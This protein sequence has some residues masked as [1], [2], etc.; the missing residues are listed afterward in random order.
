[1]KMLGETGLNSTQ[2]GVLLL[3][4]FDGMHVGHRRLLE[5][6][7]SLEIPVGIM[8]IL[9]GKGD[10]LFT[11]K[12]RELFFTSLGI[13]FSFAFSFE[14]IRGLSSQEFLSF[15]EA[16][17]SPSAYIC[18]DDFRFGKGAEG[19]ATLL[20]ELASVPVFVEELYKVNGEK[21]SSGK[22]KELLFKGEIESANEL[23]GRE[24]FLV[25][26]VE[27]GRKI[28]RTMGFP[29]ANIRYPQGKFPL[30]Q[31]V[32]ETRVSVDGKIHAGITNFGSRPTFDNDEVWTETHLKGFEGDLYGKTLCVSFVKFLREIRKFDSADALKN[33]LEEDLN[34]VGN[35]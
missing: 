34:N 28:G 33:Q 16:R 21:V 18:G 29:T 8:T 23:L 14:D 31:G 4:G 26:E 22:V 9:G 6:A 13:D 35:N 32:Y 2:G 5:R 1:M 27:T 17:F 15:L 10:G 11:L 3:G 12:E 19:N 24:F 7:K 20:K 25:G 30:K